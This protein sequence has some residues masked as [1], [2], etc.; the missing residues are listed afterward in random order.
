MN[1]NIKPITPEEAAKLQNATIEAEYKK[2]TEK[3]NAVLQKEWYTGR[4]NPVYISAP[5]K[6]QKVVM[7]LKEAFEAAGWDIKISHNQ[8]DGSS[9][10]FCKTNLKNDT[11]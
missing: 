1:E 6:H 10:A 3:I 11:D 9:W 4:L 5:P 8:R 7:M 2:Y